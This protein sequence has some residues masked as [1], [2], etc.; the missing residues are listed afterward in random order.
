M[1]KMWQH[2]FVTRLFQLFCPTDWHMKS[3]SIDVDKQCPGRM[4]CESSL[5]VSWKCQ[6]HD[7]SLLFWHV[8]VNQFF[9][10]RTYWFIAVHK[11]WYMYII[12]VWCTLVCRYK[13]MFWS[14][15]L[16][17]AT[18]LFIKNVFIYPQM[19]SKKKSLI[20]YE[21]KQKTTHEH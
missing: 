11:K 9:K 19:N 21:T 12:L 13:S 1:I 7:N 4:I 16:Q 3:M 18:I 5:V 14:Y 8:N 15:Q 20:P 10:Y 2:A 6:R 17:N